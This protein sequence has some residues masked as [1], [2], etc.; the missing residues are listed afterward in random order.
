VHHKK[1]IICDTGGKEG[2][3]KGKE[4]NNLQFEWRR[5]DA[6]G[7]TNMAGSKKRGKKRGGGGGE[8]SAIRYIGVQNEEGGLEAANSHAGGRKLWREVGASSRKE[9]LDA[10]ELEEKGNK[11]EPS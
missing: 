4:Q 7:K 10:S 11:R 2:V 5:K 3:A 9:G 8:Y 6:K 1:R